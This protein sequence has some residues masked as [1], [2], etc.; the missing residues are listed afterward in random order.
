MI[1]H[2]T[3][4]AMKII[5]SWSLKNKY[6]YIQF[7]AMKPKMPSKN[8]GEWYNYS[9]SHIMCGCIINKPQSIFWNHARNQ[10]CTLEYRWL[11]FD[12]LA[13]VSVVSYR[14]WQPA[15]LVVQPVE[16]RHQAHSNGSPHPGVHYCHLHAH[17][18]THRHK[19]LLVLFNCGPQLATLINC[20]TLEQDF[21]VYSHPCGMIRTISEWIQ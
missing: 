7:R 12:L 1:H 9:C 15:R 6:M 14:V 11:W 16:F 5:I 4:S 20:N 13:V 10:R 2:K 17:R 21:I 19:T 18:Q 3:N 8:L